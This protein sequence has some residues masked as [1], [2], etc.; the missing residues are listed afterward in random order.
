MI[1]DLLDGPF[2]EGE[3][4]PEMSWHV[5]C[6]YRD[7]PN[8]KGCCVWAME[9]DSQATI[10]PPTL[11]ITK[12]RPREKKKRLLTIRCKVC[13]TQWLSKT[14]LIAFTTEKWRYI[15]FHSIDGWRL[16]YLNTRYFI[17]GLILLQCKR[18][19][20]YWVGSKI[21]NG[22]DMDWIPFERIREQRK[23]NSGFHPHWRQRVVY[24]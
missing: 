3:P 12:C 23:Q 15:K 13:M 9:W 2:A 24:Y 5:M 16:Y 8:W 14:N 4:N 22:R 11:E 21:I 1:A 18:N 6:V 19:T 7:Q 20:P 17:T 10:D